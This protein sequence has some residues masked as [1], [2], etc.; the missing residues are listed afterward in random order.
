MCRISTNTPFAEKDLTNRA[1]AKGIMNFN[2]KQGFWVR[3]LK[4][5]SIQKFPLH[6]YTLF[7]AN[8]LISSLQQSHVRKVLLPVECA[9]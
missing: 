8:S 9:P 2:D 7:P 4:F 3:L 5:F 6:Y 1:H